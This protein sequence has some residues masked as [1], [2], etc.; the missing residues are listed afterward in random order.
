VKIVLM[1]LASGVCLMVACRESPCP[2]SPGSQF[3]SYVGV[4]SLGG[5]PATCWWSFRVRQIQELHSALHYLSFSDVRLHGD[6]RIRCVDSIFFSYERDSV[7]HP[8][9]AG[10]Q[11]RDDVYVIERDGVPPFRLNRE[12]DGHNMTGSD[13]G[14]VKQLFRT[15]ADN[16]G[17][18]SDRE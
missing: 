7:N 10:E 5:H 18:E 13:R 4:S 1:V 17:H 12:I 11:H 15:T 9:G 3:A 2:D 6:S 8:R 16:L 14:N